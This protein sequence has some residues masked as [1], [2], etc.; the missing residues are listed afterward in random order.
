MSD[1][2]ETK[3]FKT[4]SKRLL[5]LMI[6]SIYSNKEIFLRELISNASDANDKYHYLSLTN[7]KLDKTKELSIR[8]TPDK[9]N[10]TLTIEDTGIGMTY[11]EINKNLGTIA[12]SGS[13]EFIKKL[14]EAEKSK[15]DE[16][17]D[18]IGQ[19]GVGFYSAF[20]V[21]KKVEVETKSPFSD[22]AY[23]FSSEGED[24]YTVEEIEKEDN[25]SKVIVYLR[26]DTE[27]EHYSSYLE[28]YEIEGLVKKY[29]DYVRYPIKMLIT[30]TVPDRDD[31]GEII[32]DKTHEEIEDRVLNSMIPLWKR[33]KKDVT[34]EQLNDFYK[35]KYY[36]SEDPFVSSFVS[37]EGDISYNALLFIPRK[38]PYDLYSDKFEKGLQL[39]TK[40][41]FIMDKCK[42]LLPDYLRFV[43]GLVDSSDLSLNISR[44]IL[45]ESPDL[46]K[47]SNNIEKKIIKELETMKKNDFAKYKEFFETYGQFLKWGIY[48][49]YGMK[50]DLLQDLLIYKSSN[51]DDYITLRQYFE[52]KKADQKT[53]YYATGESKEAIMNLP[54]M[55]AMK[56]NEFDVLILTDKIDEFA[57]QMIN[58]YEDMD[59]KPITAADLDVSSAEDKK[60]VEDLKKEQEPLLNK[61]KEVL[62]DKVEDVRFSTRLVD[63]PVCLASSE[64]MSFGM[65]KAINELPNQEKV[66]TGRILELNPNHDLLKAIEKV[67]ANNPDDINEY[68]SLLFNQA[69]LIEGLPLEN[70]SEFS[71]QMVDLMI[72]SA[73]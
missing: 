62:K 51:H 12:S 3:E 14:E 71:K 10:R 64:G 16:S 61:L 54:Q 67:Y 26:D 55:D 43:K 46:K 19:F 13:A 30:K 53:I 2:V 9:K 63:S 22:K 49:N 21:A 45:Q 5:D 40:G 1:K 50:K 33:N 27:E 41:V 17:I 52:E 34:E 58:K 57:L 4:E 68:A 32:K 65:E 39:Y 37:V 23:R 18:I 24:S 48:D 11:E 47:I 15:N 56:K 6:H 25:G 7:D 36:A 70:P 66:K 73:K 20:M 35:K 60:K 44:E 72:K 29:S 59:F 31:K 8:I 38:A 28:T 69:L 42:D